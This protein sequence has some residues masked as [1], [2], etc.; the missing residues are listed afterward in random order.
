MGNLINVG[1]YGSGDRGHPVFAE[2]LYC[3]HADECSAYANGK[4]MGVTH[5][6]YPRCPFA[7]IMHEKGGGNRSKACEILRTKVKAN[8][9]YHKLSYP[10]HTNLLLTGDNAVLR[11]TFVDV[12]KEDK[13]TRLE[14]PLFRSS[15]IALN[16]IE[17]T[18]DLLHRI[19]SFSPKYFGGGT[20]TEYKSNIVP[21]FL[22]ELSNLFPDEYAE[23]TCAHPE[24]A[25]LT[26]DYTGRWA[27]IKTLNR[28][29]TIQDPTG[30]I[31]HFDGEYIVCPQYKSAFT[32]FL[33]TNT[34]VEIRIRLTED[35]VCK[36]ISNEQVT[37][38]T[39]F[40]D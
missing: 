8:E 12:I 20:I 35:S 10:T 24:Y 6:F 19:C 11:L 37:E 1:L 17:L 28:S 36:I 9:R 14:S 32:P 33:R 4:C 26:P 22:K 5:G 13:T 25:N 23:L 31:F 21:N 30:N 38:D 16:K 27:K 39:V 40:I 15:I 2:W 29:T 7:R 18:P 34:P 3:D